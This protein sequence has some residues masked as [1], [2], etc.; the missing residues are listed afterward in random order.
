MSFGRSIEQ[1]LMMHQLSPVISSLERTGL[2]EFYVAKTIHGIFE[3]SNTNYVSR[4]E[5]R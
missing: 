1:F 3:K 4:N 2:A 5:M